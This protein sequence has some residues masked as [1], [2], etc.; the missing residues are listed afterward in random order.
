MSVI[1]ISRLYGC[2]GAHF[3]RKL[4]EELNYAYF[5]KEIFQKVAEMSNISINELKALEGLIGYKI[6]I[7]NKFISSDFIKKIV[8]VASKIPEPEEIVKL[9]EETIIEFAKINRVVIVGRGSQCILK[10]FPNS[11]HIKI[12]ATLEDR[13]KYLMKK[14]TSME[15]ALSTIKRMDELRSNYIKKFYNKDWMDPS[16]YHLVINF[17]KVSE[18]KAIDIIKELIDYSKEE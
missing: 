9:I 8:G 13:I 12:V 2:G 15:G 7:I 16:L 17:S 18:D 6:D 4:A 1:T 5:D 14:G 11:Y 10:D 3:A